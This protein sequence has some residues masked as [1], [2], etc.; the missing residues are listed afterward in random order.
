[1]GF[2]LNLGQ[3]A[4][5]IICKEDGTRGTITGCGAFI[6][7][8]FNDTGCVLKAFK[9]YYGGSPYVDKVEVSFNTNEAINGFTEG[10]YDFVV[11]D[12]DSDI[13]RIKNEVGVDTKIAGLLGSCYFGLNLESSSPLVTNKDARKAINLAINKDRIVKEIIGRLGVVSKGPIPPAMLNGVT[14]KGYEYNPTL[15]K[16]LLQKVGVSNK[17][18]KVNLRDTD[19]DNMNIKIV[20]MIIEDLSAV[21]IKC[22]VKVV[23]ASEY[24]K[25]ATIKTCDAF[26]SRW[27]ADTGDLDNFLQ[28]I[29]NYENV[30]NFVRYNN[31]EVLELLNKAK[32]IINPEKRKEVY[33]EIQNIIV[34]D[35]PWV[36]IY[37]PQKAY[38]HKNNLLGLRQSVTGSYRYDDIILS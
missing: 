3:S 8:S 18:L 26:L 27:I 25:P 17:V 15:A 5:S 35:A 11:V 22:E 13:T 24:M 2:L 23:A 34:D 20:N 31:V 37:H 7:E 30:T 16:S 29:F 9:D 12:N 36:F 28:P 6:L 32:K 33:K 1:M 38:A 4:T 14:G 10:K 21:G 19:K